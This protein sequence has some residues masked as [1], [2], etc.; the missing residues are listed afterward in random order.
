MRQFG[1]QVLRG[2][3]QA[4]AR[5]SQVNLSNRTPEKRAIE[6]FLELSNLV[7]D[8]ALGQTKLLRREAEAQVPR[9]RLEDF[10]CVQRRQFMFH[11]LSSREKLL[12][13]QVKSNSDEP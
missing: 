11:G 1:E 6:T 5:F 3:Q 9:R 12:M 13:P 8:R 10:Q 2:L 4:L 7:T